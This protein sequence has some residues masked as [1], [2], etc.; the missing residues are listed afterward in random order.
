MRFKIGINISPPKRINRLFGIAN[1]K[2]TQ[3]V[4]T[5]RRIQVGKNPVLHRIGVLKFI[6]QGKRILFTNHTGQALTVATL[7]RLIQT[8]QHVI[9]GHMRQ[10]LFF[11]IVTLPDPMDSVQ[12]QRFCHV[13][14]FLNM[15]GQLINGL[16]GSML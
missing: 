12:S 6:N 1:H 8:R 13:Y 9:K 7:Q 14:F 3:A 4:I 16:K 5:V 11:G 2:T 10:A 15:R